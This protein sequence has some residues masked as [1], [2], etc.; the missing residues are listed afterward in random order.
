[1]ISFPIEE[2]IPKLNSGSFV[3]PLT[4][5]GYSIFVTEMYCILTCKFYILLIAEFF[6]KFAHLFLVFLAKPADQNRIVFLNWVDQ[7]YAK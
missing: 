4:K 3:I 5:L 2:Y 1:M 6:T 7:T